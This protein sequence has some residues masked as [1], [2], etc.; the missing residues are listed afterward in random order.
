MSASL[1]YILI[2]LGLATLV[3][4]GYYF[5]IGSGGATLSFSNNDAVMSN[6]LA[7]SQL[8]IDRRQQLEQ[9][10]LDTSLFTDPRFTSLQSYAAQLEE[11]PIGRTDPF[12]P[13]PGQPN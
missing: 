10:S 4:A 3:F 13:L 5:F 6:M 8:F 2:A 7:N 12:A 11:Q 1:K 9:V